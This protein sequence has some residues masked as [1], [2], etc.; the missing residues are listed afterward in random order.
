MAIPGDRLLTS[1]EASEM[2]NVHPDTLV[3]W[4]KLGKIKSERTAGGHRRYSHVGISDLMHT[5]YK[6]RFNYMTLEDL[7]SSS[8]NSFMIHTTTES[9]MRRAMSDTCAIGETYPWH[10]ELQLDF[11]SW[12]AFTDKNRDKLYTSDATSIYNNL[13]EMSRHWYESNG[14]KRLSLRTYEIPQEKIK[15][16][17]KKETWLPSFHRSNEE[18]LT[19]DVFIILEDSAFEKKNHIVCHLNEDLGSCYYINDQ[20]IEIA[21]QFNVVR[22]KV[23]N[24]SGDSPY[25]TNGWEYFRSWESPDGHTISEFHYDIKRDR[26][27]ETAQEASEFL[28]PEIT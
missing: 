11:Y 27:Q 23:D 24:S 15:S 4:E 16:I 18:W 26:N 1:K 7:A 22:P 17:I 6:T 8:T 19:Q 10:I 21:G 12:A 5:N 13:K 3:K 9:A 2:L 14:T 20:D 28:P 25:E